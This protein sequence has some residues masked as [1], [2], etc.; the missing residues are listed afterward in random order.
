MTKDAAPCH[1]QEGS[2]EAYQQSHL[3]CHREAPSA[4]VIL[5]NIPASPFEIASLHSQLSPAAQTTMNEK[6]SLVSLL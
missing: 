6:S 2:D 4:V 1:R 5:F 3:M